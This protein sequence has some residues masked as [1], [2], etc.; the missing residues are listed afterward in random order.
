[1]Q[2][3]ERRRNMDVLDEH[4]TIKGSRIVDIGSGDGSL[5]RALTR[6]GGHV[7]G[8]ECGAA[9]LDKARAA[10]LAG[11]ETYIEG[12]G[13][14]LP[15]EDESFDIAIFFNSLHHVP[16]DDMAQA[17]A[18]AR[19]VL[20]PGGTLCV[21]EPVAEGP[22]HDVWAL[23]DDETEVRA[24]AYEAMKAA[25]ADG[26]NETAEVQYVRPEVYESAEAALEMMERIDPARSAIIAEVRDT[27]VERFAQAG[28]PRADGGFDLDHPMRVNVMVKQTT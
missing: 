11:D 20:K 15:F 12:V 18:E 24:L 6:R 5:A 26:L 16:R 27:F 3:L 21:A 7:T 25:Q 28:S 13:Q 4:L 9:Q 23:I 17:L 2:N 19:R 8:V 1:M 14:D 10:E 22:V